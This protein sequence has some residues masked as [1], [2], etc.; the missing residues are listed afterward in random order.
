MWRRLLAKTAVACDAAC[1]LLSL[2]P[3]IDVQSRVCNSIAMTN[4]SDATKAIEASSKILV[5]K[6]FKRRTW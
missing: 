4:H 5:K 2:P 3:L 1:V 6:N